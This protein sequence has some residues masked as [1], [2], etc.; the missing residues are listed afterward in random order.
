[1]GSTEP[2]I[3]STCAALA[4][5]PVSPCATAGH[6]MIDH[7]WRERLALADRLIAIGHGAGR[8]FAI[9]CR[10][11]GLRRQAIHGAKALRARLKR[12][13]AKAD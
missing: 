3:N 1:M 13:T 4:A 8:R 11:E 12:A 2:S 9:A 5:A 7:V 6:P 10:L